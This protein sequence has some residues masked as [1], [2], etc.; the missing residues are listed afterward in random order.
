[1]IKGKL[2]SQIIERG[3]QISEYVTSKDR[4][5]IGYGHC[6]DAIEM[7]ATMAVIA[8]WP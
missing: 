8:G 5:L 2:P 6:V 3:A 7:K 4:D 1:M